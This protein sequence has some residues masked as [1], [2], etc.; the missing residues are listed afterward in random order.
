MDVWAG[1]IGA[2]AVLD[3]DEDEKLY[4]SLSVGQYLLRSRDCPEHTERKN[5]NVLEVRSTGSEGICLLVCP[6]SQSCVLYPIAEKRELAAQLC[7]EGVPIPPYSIFV[8]HPLLHQ[9][10]RCW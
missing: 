8:V 3:S 4:L 7:L 1:M 2:L 6:A 5:S 10:R 9:K